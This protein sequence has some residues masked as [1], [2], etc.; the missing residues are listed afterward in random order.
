MK[1]V[2]LVTLGNRLKTDYFPGRST[3]LTSPGNGLTVYHLL[4]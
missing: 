4:I 3:S 1:T 2:D